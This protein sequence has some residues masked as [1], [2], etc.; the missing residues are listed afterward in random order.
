MEPAPPRALSPADAASDD[1]DDADTFR[2]GEAPASSDESEEQYSAPDED[3]T[4]KT[5]EEL[6]EEV[7]HIVLRRLLGPGKE[8]E[9]M[10]VKVPYIVGEGGS[11][12]ICTVGRNADVNI[13][14]GVGI[15]I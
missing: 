9:E 5:N 2:G 7:K 11:G 12:H 4:Q 14:I 8:L 13:S 1:D 10:N 3:E 15:M 6:E